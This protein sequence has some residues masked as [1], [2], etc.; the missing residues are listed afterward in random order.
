MCVDKTYLQKEDIEAAAEIIG[1]TSIKYYDLRQNRVSS[2][3]FS[4][5]A[6]LDPK[7][8]TGVYLLYMYA[9][10]CSILAKGNYNQE[11]V[12]KLAG[13]GAFKITNEYQRK[14][15]L[16]ILRLPEQMDQV[17]TDL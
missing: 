6:M 8:N 17:I 2:Y 15:V 11:T 1:I 5:D 10:L 7:G 9:R 3:K 4:F 13:E 14:L 12:Q 16:A